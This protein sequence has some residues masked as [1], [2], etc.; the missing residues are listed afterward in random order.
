MRDLRRLAKSLTSEQ[1]KQLVKIKKNEEEIDELEKQRKNLIG[2]VRVLERKIVSLVGESPS[3]LWDNE[4]K[5]KKA[6]SKKCEVRIS[7]AIHEVMAAQDKPMNVAMIVEALLETP[8][9]PPTQDL[10]KLK[11]HVRVVLNS[12]NSFKRMDKGLYTIT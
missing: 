5:G 3:Q 2:K 9:R 10:K 11:N 6:G 1:V 4:M 7:D 12:N 8:Y